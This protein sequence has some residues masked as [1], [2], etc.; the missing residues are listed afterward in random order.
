MSGKY[1]LVV[2]DEFLV[3]LDME[4]ILADAGFEVLG[5][6]ASVVEALRLIG[7]QRPNAALLDNNLNGQS[8]GPV[9]VALND[10]NVPFA[11]VTG[12]DRDSLPPGFNDSPMVRKPFNPNG[13]ITM[14]RTLLDEAGV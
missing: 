4:T 14:A 9:A 6:V 11:F 1:I 5:P 3:A 8:V 7:V 2:E 13:L 10:R 12:N